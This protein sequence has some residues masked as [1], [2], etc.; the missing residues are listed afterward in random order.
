MFDW[1]GARFLEHPPGSLSEHF[2]LESCSLVSN[3]RIS[4]CGF[5]ISHARILSRVPVLSPIRSED[6]PMTFAMV[7]QRL[8]IGVPSGKRVWWPVRNCPPPRPAMTV[9]RLLHTCNSMYDVVTSVTFNEG[10]PCLNSEHGKYSSTQ[11]VHHAQ[12]L[13]ADSQ[14]RLN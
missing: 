4:P 9:G 3:S 10:V 1:A 8:A 7:N 12:P 11:R 5:P 13:P 14:Q 6:S 2:F